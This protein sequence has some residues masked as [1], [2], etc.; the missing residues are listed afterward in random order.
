MPFGNLKVADVK[1]NSEDGGEAGGQG[2][3]AA[4]LMGSLSKSLF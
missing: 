2:P 3:P 4:F 1:A